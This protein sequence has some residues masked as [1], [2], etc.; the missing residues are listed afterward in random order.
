M[1]LT[2][3]MK[4]LRLPD[5]DAL[6]GRL[7]VS[8]EHTA[9][10]MQT[11]ETYQKRAQAWKENNVSVL[12]WTGATF[13]SASAFVLLFGVAGLLGLFTPKPQKTKRAML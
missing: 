5:G 6:A 2:S 4:T 8:K 9:I 11:L 1:D 3:L 13:G 7:G 12:G 10:L